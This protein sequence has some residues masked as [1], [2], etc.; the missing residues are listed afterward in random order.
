MKKGKSHQNMEAGT[1]YLDFNAYFII[2]CSIIMNKIHLK[3]I[4]IN[5]LIEHC[6]SDLNLQIVQNKIKYKKKLCISQLNNCRYFNLSIY[7]LEMNNNPLGKHSIFC[8]N[9]IASVANMQ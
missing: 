3:K 8:P 1:M 5:I 7:K 2:K 6:F 4:N 9:F